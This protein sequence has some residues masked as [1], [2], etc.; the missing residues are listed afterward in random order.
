M[1]DQAYTTCLFCLKS[2][3]ILAISIKNSDVSFWS[4]ECNGQSLPL[5]KL[6]GN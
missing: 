6:E 5:Y 3:K 4:V 1:E 2:H